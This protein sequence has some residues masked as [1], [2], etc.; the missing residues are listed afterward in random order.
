MDNASI[1]LSSACPSADEGLNY[2]ANIDIL[3]IFATHQVP[4]I[5]Y[6]L[7]FLPFKT[8]QNRIK[9]QSKQV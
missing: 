6:L 8:L 7:N 5:L 1:V 3:E 2:L 4:I 9:L